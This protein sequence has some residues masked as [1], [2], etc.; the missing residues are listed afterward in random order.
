VS[1]D[2]NHN[3][4]AV[5]SDIESNTKRP[6]LYFGP[7]FERMASAIQCRVIVTKSGYIGIA[8]ALASQGDFVS[9]VFGVKYIKVL[10]PVKGLREM[11]YQVVGNSFV[12]DISNINA[13]KAAKLSRTTVI[14]C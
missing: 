14:L 9:L 6:S 11:R 10:R 5:P 8:S 2:G 12:L 1:S 4:A 7:G 3:S 13:S